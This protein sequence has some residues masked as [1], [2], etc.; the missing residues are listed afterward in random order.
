M[1]LDPV[2]PVFPVFPVLPD[3]VF[4]VLP[5][6]VFPVLP[7]PVFPVL[8]DPVFP[9]LPDPELGLGDL[10]LPEGSCALL[11]GVLEGPTVTTIAMITTATMIATPIG[12][13]I[14]GQVHHGCSETSA[15]PPKART[16]PSPRPV[17]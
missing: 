5:D 1:L 14:L 7:D 15:L 4:P 2:F 11:V 10:E 8:P 6:P 3:P 9:V 16:T 12:A 13:R 17:A